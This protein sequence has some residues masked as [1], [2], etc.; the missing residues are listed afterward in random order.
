MIHSSIDQ[1]Q[2]SSHR[3]ANRLQTALLLGF[4]TAYAGFLGWLLWG[5]DGIWTIMVW[6]AIILIFSPGISSKWI[7]RMYSARPV[8]HDQA[9]QYHQLLRVLAQRSDLPRVPS[10]W[11]IPSNMVNAFAVGR[12]NDSAIAVTQGLLQ[13]L[14]PRELAGVLAHETAHIAHGDLFVMGLADT[15]SRVTAAM[16]F[17]GLILL[18]LSL[19]QLLFGGHVNWLPLLLLTVAPQI[20]LLAQLGL[21]RT[22]EFDADLT[23]AQLTD[24][25]EGLALALDK[26]ERIQNQGFRRIFMPGQGVPEPSWLRTHPTS[27]ERIRRLLD[28]RRPSQAWPHDLAFDPLELHHP[29]LHRAP[30]G[31]LWGYWR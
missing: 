20:S 2:V 17:T 18:L 30:R 12:K 24:D 9:P 3:G 21:S 10:L 7:L 25:P 29:R 6:C 19:P 31:G 5:P 8:H 15:I 28:L 11:W 22:R 1:Q 13:S 16:S 27:A 23:A 14:S 4:M 26:L